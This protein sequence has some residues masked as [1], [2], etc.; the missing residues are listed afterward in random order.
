MTIHIIFAFVYL[1]L[2]MWALTGSVEPVAVILVMLLVNIATTVAYATTLYRYQK[3][4]EWFKNHIRLEKS[5]LPSD[6]P[7]DIADGI[8]YEDD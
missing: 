8:D 2:I 3:I 1:A 4:F 7:E 5:K 6:A